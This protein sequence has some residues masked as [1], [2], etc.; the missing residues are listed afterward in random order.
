V[1]Q[2]AYNSLMLRAR[3]SIRKDDKVRLSVTSVDGT[4]FYDQT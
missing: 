1:A 2:Q 4:L 3:M